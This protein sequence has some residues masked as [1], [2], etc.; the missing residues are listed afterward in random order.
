MIKELN[1]ND[2]LIISHI[3]DID[4]MGSVIL[5]KKYFDNKVDYI[6]CNNKDLLEIFS[7]DLTKYQTIFVCD[8]SFMNNVI[9]ILK[10][11]PISLK[12][13]HF[14]HHKLYSEKLDFINTIANL[15]GR[16]TCGTERF[17]NYLN[18]LSNKL[19]TKF[20]QDFVEAIREQDTW[21]FGLQEKLA[22]NLAAFHSLI[23]VTGYI[24]YIC[25]L[26]DTKEF[27]LSKEINDILKAQNNVMINYIEEYKN[28]MVISTINNNRVGIV[29]SEQYRSY[30]G[31]ELC[32]AFKEIDYILIIN[33]NRMS[34][35]LRTIKEIDLSSIAKYYH[36]EGGGHPKA[37][38]FIIDENSMPILKEIIKNYLDNLL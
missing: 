12:I 27:S 9:E 2:V 14:D 28:K 32:Q 26:D 19:N 30:L 1:N 10:D 25:S 6:L 17:Y 15:N 4:G 20:Y 21:D 23:G 22:N 16:L 24:E 13:K 33:F 37:S 31:H 3:A 11:N 5:G 36:P 34:C 29:I 7:M 18:S 38:G 35:S 8:L